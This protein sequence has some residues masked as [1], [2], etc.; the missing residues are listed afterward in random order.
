M[1]PEEKRQIEMERGAEVL[2]RRVLARRFDPHYE[3]GEDESGPKI[4][5]EERK[6]RDEY[7]ARMGAQ[8]A[9]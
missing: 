6:R 7:R 2:A 5:A 3:P 1:S 4:S 9:K 8:V